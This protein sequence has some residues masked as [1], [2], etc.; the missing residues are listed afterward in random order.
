[1]GQ[2]FNYVIPGT[3]YQIGRDIVIEWIND[4]CPLQFIGKKPLD[5]LA[6]PAVK[7]K[8]WLSSSLKK[9]ESAIHKIH[10][11]GTIH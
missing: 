9:H 1:M 2:A 11:M 6:K 5:K 8:L 3:G 10:G 7:E 4:G